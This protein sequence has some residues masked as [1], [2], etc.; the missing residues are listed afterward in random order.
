MKKIQENGIFFY[1]GI[2][3]RAFRRNT[4]VSFPL[5]RLKGALRFMM[6]TNFTKIHM[7]VLLA[8]PLIGAKTMA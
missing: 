1:F 7:C 5:P 8:G 3:L 2:A 4:A 6:I